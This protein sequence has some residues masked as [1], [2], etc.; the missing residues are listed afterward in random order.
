VVPLRLYGVSFCKSCKH[1]VKAATFGV[2]TCGAIITATPAIAITPAQ[3]PIAA[4]YPSY[5][6]WYSGDSKPFE[7]AEPDPTFDGLA[8]TYMG[9]VPTSHLVIDPYDHWSPSR[10][11]YSG[12]ALPTT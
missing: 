6:P 3:V 9:T 5:Q 10:R 4:H 12:G 7:P 1:W 11:H 2:C 8:V